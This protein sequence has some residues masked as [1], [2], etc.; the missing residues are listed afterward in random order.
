MQNNALQAGSVALTGSLAVHA[1][2]SPGGDCN[3]CVITAARLGMQAA[4][5]LTNTLA[6]SPLAGRLQLLAGGFIGCHHCPE[7]PP[8]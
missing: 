4:Q 1:Q 8:A 7:V 5:H 2:L 6:A 3:T